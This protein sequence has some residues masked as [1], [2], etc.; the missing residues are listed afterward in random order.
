[1]SIFHSNKCEGK[2]RK[3]TINVKCLFTSLHQVTH[4]VLR[5]SGYLVHMLLSCQSTG[6]HALNT[7]DGRVNL[8]VLSQ[9]YLATDTTDN[10]HVHHTG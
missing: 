7:L 2:Y 9:L 8:A 10:I 5:T 6:F 4:T 1:M 3:N